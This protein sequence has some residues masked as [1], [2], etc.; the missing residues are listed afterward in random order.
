M[1][2]IEIDPAAVRFAQRCFPVPNVAWIHSSLEDFDVGLGYDFVVMIEVLEHIQDP[3]GAVKK[4]R[5]LT[6]G[7][8]V[9]LVTVPNALRARRKDERLNVNEWTPD[10]FL[11]GL[12][13]RHFPNACLMT[14]ELDPRLAGDYPDTPIIALCS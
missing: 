2:A 7:G 8:G 1:D 12:L 14:Y 13:T 10:S 6:G 4:L 3:E 9:A 11:H 5:D